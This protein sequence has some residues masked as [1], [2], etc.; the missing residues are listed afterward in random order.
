MKIA[1]KEEKY[2]ISGIETVLKDANAAFIAYDD[3]I[4]PIKA[5]FDFVK[6]FE[7]P[8]I[9]AGYIAKD[10]NTGA[11]IATISTLP[12]KEQ[13][14]AQVVGGLKAPLSGLVSVLGGSQRKFVYALA[15]VAKKK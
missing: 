4:S 5:L 13:L 15:A 6:K 8:K 3:A 11:Q 9:K 12:S 7:M 14:L 2:D 1:L 10:F